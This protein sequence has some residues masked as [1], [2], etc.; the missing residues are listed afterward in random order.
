MI[1]KKSFLGTL[2][3]STKLLFARVFIETKERW[4]RHEYQCS[5]D[6]VS[7]VGMGEPVVMDTTPIN[8]C[9]PLLLIPCNRTSFVEESLT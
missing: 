8:L 9:K 1:T 3:A 7:A 2:V 5:T 6:T 4:P